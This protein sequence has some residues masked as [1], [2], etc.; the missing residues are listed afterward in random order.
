MIIFYYVIIEIFIFNFANKQ[1]D[2]YYFKLLQE[3][4]A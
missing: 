2:E 3:K 1:R 4:Y